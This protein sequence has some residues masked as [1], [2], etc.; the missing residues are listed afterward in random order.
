MTGDSDVA[1]VPDPN[2]MSARDWTDQV[3]LC[4]PEA[5]FSILSNED[6]FDDW[7]NDTLDLDVFSEHV[8]PR[9][10]LFNSWQEWAKVFKSIVET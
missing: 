7:V 4:W 3:S 9:S 5:T 8:I 6:Y 1:Q 10:D 2:N